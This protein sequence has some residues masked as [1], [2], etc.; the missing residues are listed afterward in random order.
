MGK[1]KIQVTR[2]VK[3]NMQIISADRNQ[4]EL[5]QY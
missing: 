4:T 2:N 3:L 5:Q 1:K